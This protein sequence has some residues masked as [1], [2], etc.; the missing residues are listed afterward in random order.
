MKLKAVYSLSM[1]SE[2]CRISMTD[3]TNMLRIPGLTV[4]NGL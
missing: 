4:E 3:D 1:Q 2:S